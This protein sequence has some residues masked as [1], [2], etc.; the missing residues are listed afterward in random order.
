MP[1]FEQVEVESYE[2]KRTITPKPTP[3]QN[4][5]IGETLMP[6]KP[7][8]CIIHAVRGPE[9]AAFW[10]ELER[11]DNLPS[12]LNPFVR[13]TVEPM[14]G[15]GMRIPVGMWGATLQEWHEAVEFASQ[16]EHW[17]HEHPQLMVRMLTS[18]K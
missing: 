4:V 11:A 9:N 1:N 15:W 12:V 6:S 8:E 3:P 10:H 14:E 2:R 13:R 16:M 5:I 17:N 7:H 18:G